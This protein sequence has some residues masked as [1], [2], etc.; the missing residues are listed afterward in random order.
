M[1]TW[2]K[3]CS[4]NL[5]TSPKEYCTQMWLSLAHHLEA[6]GAFLAWRWN[7]SYTKSFSKGASR[8]EGNDVDI[9][10]WSLFK[11]ASTWELWYEWLISPIEIVRVIAQNQE[12]LVADH[13]HNQADKWSSRL[14]CFGS[15]REQS[16]QAM[17]LMQTWLISFQLV[18]EWSKT[19]KNGKNKQ[20]F[21]NL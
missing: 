12:L 4:R 13:S 18:P 9:E 10:T 6:A 1:L 14:D 16:R 3:I 15:Q 8:C 20:S 21:M 2:S 19:E 17:G 5:F 11:R 7:G